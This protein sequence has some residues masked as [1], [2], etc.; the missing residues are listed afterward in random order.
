ML[1]NRFLISL[2]TQ[3]CNLTYKFF[4]NINVVSNG[5]RKKLLDIGVSNKKI[6]LIYNWSLPI[7]NYKSIHF[8]QYREI[9]NNYFTIVYAGNIGQAQNLHIILDVVEDFIKNN[10]QGI[11]FFIIGSG[12]EKEFLEKEVSK[13]GLGDYIIFTGFIPSDNVGQFL[14]NA[15]VLFLHLRKIPLFDITIPS[16]LVSYFIYS[17]PILCGVGGESAE[18]VLESNSGFCFEPEN[19]HDLKKNILKLKEITE[20]EREEMGK[21]GRNLYDTLFSFEIGTTKIINEVKKLTN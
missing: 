21:S 8:D 1:K 3:Y 14:E 5:Y 2:L 6:S 20:T 10:I 4:D 17:K 18:I 19:V 15:S 11:K 7:N 13:R 16:K 9:F 12:V